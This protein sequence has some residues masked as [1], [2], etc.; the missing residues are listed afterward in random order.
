MA[1][2][3]MRK[4]GGGTN[5]PAA[6]S[7]WK[8]SETTFVDD[9]QDSVSMSKHKDDGHEEDEDEGP[10]FTKER[11][12][13]LRARVGARD[14]KQKAERIMYAYYIVIA[15]FAYGFYKSLAR[16]GIDYTV[17]IYA[18]I[19]IGIL[20]LAMLFHMA[21]Y[22]TDNVFVA[23]IAGM[24]AITGIPLITLAAFVYVWVSV[25]FKHEWRSQWIDYVK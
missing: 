1:T 19:G 21:S 25:F 8:V 7:A 4:R 17:E 24:L 12:R 10:R 9:N 20:G 22:T 11:L 18:Q 3:K 15:A 2:Q 16:N 6:E 5:E 13:E 14:I 23:A